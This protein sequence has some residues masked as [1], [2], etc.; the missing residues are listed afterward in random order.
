M[1]TLKFLR[2]GLVILGHAEVRACRALGRL[3]MFMANVFIIRPPFYSHV[4]WEQWLQWGLGCAFIVSITSIFTG[5]V[6]TLQIHGNFAA[7]GGQQATPSL[8]VWAL[9]QELSPVLTGI[10]VAGRAG[11]ALAAQLSSMKISQ[12]FDVLAVMNIPLRSYLLTPSLWMAGLLTPVLVGFSTVLGIFSSYSLWVGYLHENG[13]QFLSIAW[14]AWQDS[15]WLYG[16][17]KGSIF[18]IIVALMAQTQGYFLRTLS[19]EGMRRS[20]TLT[21]VGASALILIVNYFLSAWLFRS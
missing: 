10:M 7:W 16:W 3:V 9:A 20:M 14:N 8:V 5:L 13:H 21:V 2:S 17:I 4:W 18:G 12:H 6:L 11:S 15:Q 19:I 1:K